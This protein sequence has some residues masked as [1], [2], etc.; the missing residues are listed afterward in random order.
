MRDIPGFEGRYAVTSCG[1]VYSYR[2]KKFMKQCGE[3]NNYQIVTLC[4]GKGNNKSY[5]VHR[6][7]ALAYLPNPNNYPEVN[8]KN[9]KK[10]KNNVQNLEWCTKEYN[11]MYGTR[12]MRICKPVYC[13]EL[14]KTYPSIF[15]ACRALN[16]GQANLSTHLSK[17]IPKSVGGYHFRYA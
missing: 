14:D 11:L 8:H 2:Q 17:N 7:V 5:Y 1:K 4:D 9:E 15:K 12:C 13:I 6:L 10:D 16:I 3:E